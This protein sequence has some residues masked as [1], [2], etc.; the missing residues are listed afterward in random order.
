MLI[1]WRVRRNPEVCPC[2]YASMKDELGASR[3]GWDKG[4][5]LI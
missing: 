2:N 5:R 4:L 1:S 3:S